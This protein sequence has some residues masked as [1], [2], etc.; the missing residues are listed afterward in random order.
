MDATREGTIYSDRFAAIPGYCSDSPGLPEYD[1][2]TPMPFDVAPRVGPAAADTTP[3]TTRLASFDG[4]FQAIRSCPNSDS[5]MP[6]A[7]GSIRELSPEQDPTAENVAL[8]GPPHRPAEGTTPVPATTPDAIHLAQ[9]VEAL[10][11]ENEMLRASLPGGAGGTTA[12]R[13]AEV[14]LAANFASAPPPA[15]TQRAPIFLE[16]SVV[17]PPPPLQADCYVGLQA[18]VEAALP[19]LGSAGH[20]AGCCKPCVHFHK[21]GCMNGTQC[22]FCHLCDAGEVKRRQ[23]RKGAQRQRVSQQLRGHGAGVTTGKAAFQG[24]R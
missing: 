1:Y 24:N 12:A 11:A 10:R 21:K 9:L 18:E 14:G 4:F 6:L 8:A 13:P 3:R 16:S 20:A 22:P 17:P 15:P 23:A 5:S 7:I 2:P 19:S